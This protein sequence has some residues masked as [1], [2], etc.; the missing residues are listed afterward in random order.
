MSDRVDLP[1]KIPA[2]LALI[3]ILCASL[4]IVHVIADGFLMHNSQ[5]D[6]N[7]DTG[8]GNPDLEEDDRG[9]I[10]QIRGLQVDDWMTIT[11]SNLALH[12]AFS[13][14]VSPQLPPPNS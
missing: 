3:L 4:L 14:S 5:V 1:L 2:G 10:S 7:S 12:R 11:P 6:V 9:L 8:Q 13:F